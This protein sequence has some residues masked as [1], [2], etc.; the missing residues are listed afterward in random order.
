MLKV[1]QSKLNA[2]KRDNN[3]NQNQA[4]K[5]KSQDKIRIVNRRKKPN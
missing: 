2:D 1:N 5:L 3:K 4:K